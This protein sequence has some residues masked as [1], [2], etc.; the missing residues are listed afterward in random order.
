M[1][2]LTRIFLIIE[3]RTIGRIFAGGPC[4][5]PGFGRGVSIP[6]LIY[7]G[8]LPV[9]AVMFSSVAIPLC[10]SGGP[11]FIYSAFSSSS[12]TLFRLFVHLDA[13]SSSSVV[14][15]IFISAGFMIVGRPYICCYR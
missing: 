6:D 5:L 3:S 13:F 15:G 12:P 4:F 9:L 1:R 11:Y 8:Y 14:K 2:Q 7:A 10:I